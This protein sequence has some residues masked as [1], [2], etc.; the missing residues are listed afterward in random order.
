VREES[1]SVELAIVPGSE[2]GARLL[3]A[4]PDLAERIAVWMAQRLHAGSVGEGA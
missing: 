3:A 1:R 4:Q 2:H